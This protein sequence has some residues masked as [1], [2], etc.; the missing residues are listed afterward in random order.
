MNAAL[1][2]ID[3]QQSF[4]ARPYWQKTDVPAFLHNLQT[5]IDQC[6]AQHVPV[7]QVLHVNDP[8][9]HGKDDPFTVDSG[10]VRTLDGLNIRPTAVFH[11]NV[12][13]SMFGKN[14]QGQTLDAWLRAQGITTVLVTGIRTEQCC[15]T[16]TRHANDLGY[17]VR[18][19]TDA[20]LTFAMQNAA[21]RVFSAQD[22]C[23]RTEL[24]LADRFARIA[25]TRN[26]LSI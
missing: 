11:K 14:A 25:S 17:D 13:S 26:A 16:T 1:L 19:V 18:F 22:I 7:L 21:G 24:V 4:T 15:E 23:E 3:V 10:H 8:P 5:L 6:E 9:E 20:T 12:H 2:V